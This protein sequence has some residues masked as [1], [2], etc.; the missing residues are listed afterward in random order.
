MPLRHLQLA[1]CSEI[2]IATPLTTPDGSICPEI[3]LHVAHKVKA[4]AILVADPRWRCSA[5]TVTRGARRSRPVH[6][7]LVHWQ[8][9]QQQPLTAPTPSSVL[10]PR[11]AASM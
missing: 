11:G 10:T 7:K 8:Y 6:R 9:A 1:G 5:R 3:M 2:I 4:T